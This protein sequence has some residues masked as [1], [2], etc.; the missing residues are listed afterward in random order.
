MIY[1]ELRSVP[2][3]ISTAFEATAG[4]EEAIPHTGAFLRHLKK[5]WVVLYGDMETRTGQQAMSR[6][7]TY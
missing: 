2:P 3:K 6:E 1:G 4:C 5:I 7:R